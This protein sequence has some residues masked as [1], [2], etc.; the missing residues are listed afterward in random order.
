[1]RQLDVVEFLL[2]R[3]SGPNVCDVSLARPIQ[4]RASC[5]SCFSRQSILPRL[6]IARHP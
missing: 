6:F 1:M 3:G 2:M 4:V 5:L